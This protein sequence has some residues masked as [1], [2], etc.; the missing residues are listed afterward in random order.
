MAAHT[1]PASPFLN[2]VPVDDTLCAGA[3]MKIDHGFNRQYGP[4]SITGPSSNGGGSAGIW[5]I[6]S[7]FLHRLE[8]L[9]I[10]S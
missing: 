4:F 8:L 3:E 2:I 7:P 9:R 6:T 10:E 5:L 1:N